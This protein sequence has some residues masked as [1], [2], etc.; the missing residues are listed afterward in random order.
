MVA[1][2]RLRDEDRRD[3]RDDNG[4]GDGQQESR[5]PGRV[6]MV[7]A[8]PRGIATTYARRRWK[9]EQ[10]VVAADVGDLDHDDEPQGRPEH[11]EIPGERNARQEE[12]HAEGARFQPP[13]E[14][15]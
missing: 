15:P 10:C 14:P 9:S 13:H 3:E 11:R 4:P 7:R 8:R 12:D 5:R 1:P 6:A 2:V